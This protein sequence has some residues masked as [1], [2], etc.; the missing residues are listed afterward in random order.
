MAAAA[1]QP[2]DRYAEERLFK[3]L[4]MRNFRWTGADQTGTVSGGWGLR[5]RAIDMAKL[6]ML[7]LDDGRWQGRQVVPAAW[8]RQM[9]TPSPKA[10]AQD[11]GYYCWINHIVESEPEF[12]AMGF[13]GQFI[14][15]LPKERAVV[16]MTAILPTD[17]GLRTG[18]YLN[19]YRRMVND[20]ILPA[21]Q[22]LP[23]AQPGESAERALKRELELSA[24]A[25]GVPGTE[26]AFNDAPEK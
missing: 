26:L 7:M 15:V 16:V 5:L 13:K 14:T 8:I 11:Y 6:G 12:G 21:M 18:T 1:G 9:T 17:G 23:R 24:Q 10:T 19:M 25:Q 22:T 2:E 4:G 20:F 3:P